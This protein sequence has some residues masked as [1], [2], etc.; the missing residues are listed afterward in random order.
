MDRKARIILTTAVSLI[1]LVTSAKQARAQAFV[2]PAGD[3]TVTVVYQT[4]LTEQ[5]LGLYGPYDRGAI[6]SRNMIIDFS[7]GLGRKFGFSIS[8][9]LAAAQYRGINGH[10]L[11]AA[12]K[13]LYPDFVSL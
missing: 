11:N 3:G 10:Q 6:E 1:L 2:P 13:L 7:M 9:P 5:H 4:A 12:E 8:V